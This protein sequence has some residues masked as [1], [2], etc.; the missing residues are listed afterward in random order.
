MGNICRRPLAEAILRRQAQEANVNI[1]VDS[2]GS[3]DWHVGQRS[4]ARAIAVGEGRGYTMTHRARQVRPQ[5]FQ[6]FDLII[7]MDEENLRTLRRMPAFAP[8]KVHLAR[9]FDPMADSLEV[10]DPYYGTLAEFETITD[11]LE[12]ACR[13]I[14]G[15]VSKL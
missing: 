12:V 11:Q 13:G 15:E 4:D 2:A 6:T 1:E 5:D 9:S 14:V 10:E 8:E 7:V 3:G